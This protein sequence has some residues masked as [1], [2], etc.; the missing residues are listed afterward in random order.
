MK[1]PRR[2][3]AEAFDA[4]KSRGLL[5][6]ARQAV[7]QSLYH[8][9][10]ATGS[11]INKW[12][13]GSGNAT[14]GYHKRLS[15]L[16]DLGVVY[17]VEER[18]CTVTGRQAIAWDVTEHLPKTNG[19]RYQR[20]TPAEITKALDVFEHWGRLA[21]LR[22]ESVSAEVAGVLLWLRRKSA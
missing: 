14:P 11:E 7:Y 5:S 19:K 4:I 12:F 15:E 17:E 20:P 13:V 2:T 1:I 16:R 8:W 21:D 18:E 22:G 10:P 3:S 9:G 6:S